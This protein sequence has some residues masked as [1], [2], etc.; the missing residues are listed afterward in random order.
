[1][2]SRLMLLAAAMLFS[3]GGTAI[4]SCG[5]TD[6]QIAGFRC[7]VAALVLAL[8]VPASRRAW[9][10]SI[11]GVAVVYAATLVAY[12]LANKATTSANAIFLQSAAPLYILLLAPWLL[13]EKTRLRDVGLMLAMALGLGLFFVVDQP[14][15]ETAPDPGWGNVYGA[16]AGFFWALTVMG[17]RRLAAAPEARDD[18]A[19]RAVVAGNTLAFLA[20][21]PLALP[22]VRSTPEDWA[23]IAYLGIFQIAVAYRLLTRGIKGVPAF[24]ASL[25]LLAEPIFNPVWTWWMHGEVPTRGAWIGGA[26]ILVA[27]TLKTWLDTSSPQSD[28]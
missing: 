21:L 23:W 18:D 20:T 13:K 27:A 14:P 7:G 8:L 5:L 15:L 2:L 3:T 24:E 16:A 4:K 19:V 12:S 10:R 1:M 28:A 26:L 6:W 17:L 9:N 25:L 11:L 22:V